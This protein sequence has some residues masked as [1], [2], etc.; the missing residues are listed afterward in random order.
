MFGHPPVYRVLLPWI[1]CKSILT[2]TPEPAFIGNFT[3]RPL[4]IV[5][6]YSY[7]KALGGSIHYSNKENKDK[8][9]IYATLQDST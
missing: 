1:L 3:G 7:H 4:R 8:E 2:A 5:G 6:A 9:I